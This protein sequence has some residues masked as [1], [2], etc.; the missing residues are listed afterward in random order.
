MQQYR[1]TL[2]ELVAH[3]Q[4]Y[5]VAL[6]ARE[7]KKKVDPRPLRN[8]QK[9]VNTVVDGFGTLDDERKF[10]SICAR[11]HRLYELVPPRSTES[12]NH[13]PPQQPEIPEPSLDTDAIQK[14]DTLP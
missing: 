3:T 6:E 4:A 2:F 7:K 9:I 11:I 13:A 12:P 5:F 14:E 10:K 1:K 8:M